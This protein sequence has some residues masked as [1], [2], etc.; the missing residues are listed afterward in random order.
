MTLRD[1]RDYWYLLITPIW[2]VHSV[3]KNFQIRISAFVD[4]KKYSHGPR[5]SEKA[6]RTSVAKDCYGSLLWCLRLIRANSSWLQV[7]PKQRPSEP[8]NQRAAKLCSTV[9]SPTKS[10]KSLKRRLKLLYTWKQAPKTAR[11]KVLNP[12]HPRKIFLRRWEFFRRPSTFRLPSA[13]STTTAP[14]EGQF[15]P[16]HISLLAWMPNMSR[17]R[18]K[19]V[20][21]NKNQKIFFR[22][23]WPSTVRE[24]VN[25]NFC[26]WDIIIQSF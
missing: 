4:P 26:W 8:R 5:S 16:E 13:T 9:Q 18:S 15:P 1:P 17:S 23:K 21:P 2:L 10:Q 14:P 6:K 24:R 12:E 7:V 19:N 3:V 25:G 11:E 22:K 20:N